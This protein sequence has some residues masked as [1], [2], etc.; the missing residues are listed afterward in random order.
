[1][2]RLEAQLER[3]GRVLLVGGADLASLGGE[4]TKI[5]PR[6]SNAEIARALDGD[7]A[8]RLVRAMARAKVN[9]LLVDGRLEGRGKDAHDDLASRFRR[10][11]HVP[12]FRAEVL[13][14]VAALYV[15]EAP[16]TLDAKMASAI[17][18]VARGILAGRRAPQLRSFPALLRRIEPVEVMVMLRD[19]ERARLWR[20]ARSSSIGQGLITAASVARERWKERETAMGGPLTEALPRLTVE[21]SL[22][23][24]DGTLAVSPRGFL[25]RA[26]PPIHGVGFEQKGRWRYL[27]PSARRAA[28]SG[29]RAFRR[30]VEESSLDVAS[31]DRPDLRAYRFVVVVLAISP[32]SVSVAPLS[33]GRTESEEN[34][35][36]E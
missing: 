28:G 30:L 24:E 35:E 11:E 25:D 1:M 8:S 22:L 15:P 7:D 12:G 34:A 17:G 3:R 31:A 4:G 26:V 20:S 14:P 27:L 6:A 33:S 19:G 32:P 9:G 21:V 10:Y 2:E 36:A 5:V 16:P 13:A 29:S 18:T 23:V